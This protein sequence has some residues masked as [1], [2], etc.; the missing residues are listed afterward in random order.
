MRPRRIAAWW[1]A[2]AVAATLV[3]AAVTASCGVPEAG[4]T[5]IDRSE[6]PEALRPTTSST[7]TTAVPGGPGAVAVYWISGERL[8][9]EIIAFEAVPDVDRVVT[10]LERGPGGAARPE[11]AR[12]VFS[13]ADVILDATRDGD[14]VVVDLAPDFSEVTGSDQALA[15]GQIV[16]TLTSV[17]GVAQVVFRQDGETVEVP[18]PDGSLASGPLTREDYASLLDPSPGT[19][20]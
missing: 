19:N 17:P 1:R 7:S 8:V 14:R 9:P 11:G 10:L 4:T 12:S 3:A 6:L 2:L 16:A 13:K 5:R 18:V 20:R 15:V